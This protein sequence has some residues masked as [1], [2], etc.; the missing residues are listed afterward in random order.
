MKIRNILTIFLLALLIISIPLIS[1]AAGEKSI[2]FHLKT[3]LKQDDAQICVAYNEIWA[4]LEEGFDVDVL[5]DASA[6][7]TYKR[8]FFGKD[9]L[10]D[11]KLP[12]NMR[13]LLA[14][15]FKISIE[16]VPKVYGEYLKMLNDKGVIFYINSE[17]L[18]TAGIAEDENDLE[19]I[20]AKFFKPIAM[21]EIIN[22]RTKADFYMAY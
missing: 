14:N 1:Y 3:G 5:I 13:N 19:K 9:S 15:Q 22:L 7:Y 2:L 20:S 17:M 6:V 21:K 12:E 16:D 8:G 10:E 18:V 4:A 11:Y